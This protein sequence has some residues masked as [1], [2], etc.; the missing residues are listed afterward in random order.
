ML[1]KIA[2]LLCLMAGLAAC[3]QQ[4]DYQARQDIRFAV[5]QAPITL[6]PRYATDAASA[7]LNR[8]LYR[9]L[10]GFDAS[11]KPVADL[12]TWQVIR[13]TQYRFVLGQAGRTFHDGSKLNASD[14][15]ATYQS[16]LALKDS[17]LSAEFAN[18]SH[19]QVL[20]DNT[21]DFYLNAADSAFPAK[22]IIG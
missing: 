11:S 12:A 22:L 5:A 16:L 3:Q 14:V 7:R 15:Q 2:A 9:A 18:I 13:P 19:I 20:D 1:K 4:A 6:D 17:P 21:L 8:L 10:V